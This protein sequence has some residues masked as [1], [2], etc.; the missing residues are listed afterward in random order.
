MKSGNFLAVDLVGFLFCTL[1][2]LLYLS[3]DPAILVELLSVALFGVG[4]FTVWPEQSWIWGRMH[5]PGFCLLIIAVFA[6]GC[7]AS[8]SWEIN[9]DAG[10][11]D[12]FKLYSLPMKLKSQSAVCMLSEDYSCRLQTRHPFISALRIKYRRHVSEEFLAQGYCTPPSFRDFSTA[13][14][15][16][17]NAY[18]RFGALVLEIANQGWRHLLMPSKPT[19]LQMFQ[20]WSGS[21][22]VFLP[23]I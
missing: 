3:Q 14:L 23:I 19:F 10:E 7:E 15:K 18:S 8:Y 12:S 11:W 5:F 21:K 6:A 20:N 4:P 1:W 13:E 9:V 16:E 2:S 22:I 17:Q